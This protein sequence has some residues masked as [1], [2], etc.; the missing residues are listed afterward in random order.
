VE[1]AVVLPILV[2]F[3]FGIVEFGLAYSARIE[4]TNAVREGARTAALGKG[5]CKPASPEPAGYL[6]ACVVAS[7]KD[8]ASGLAPASI[9]VEP[10]L[11]PETPVPGDRAT[12]RATYPFSYDI[13]FFRS[14]TWTLTA[15]GV[16]RCGG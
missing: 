14:G 7:T 4:L 11:C 6:K 2:L 3:M 10:T 8:A 9:T 5:A 16:M 15:R 12:V 1:F 13:P